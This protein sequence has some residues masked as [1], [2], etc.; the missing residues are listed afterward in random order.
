MANNKNKTL[1][2]DPITF[3]GGS[4][5]A[6]SDALNVCRIASNEFIV[7]TVDPEFW[8]ATEFYAKHNVTLRK[9][10]A[11]SW[12]MKKHNGAFYWL[13]QLYLLL[14]MLK[15]LVIERGIAKI[16][17]ASGPG[18]DMPMYL[19]KAFLNIEVTQF[20]HGN[21]GLSRSI[22][23]CLTI[24]DAVF[25][26]PSTRKSLKVALE[27]YLQHATKIEDTSA[28][29]ESYLK[30][31][32][33]QSFVN[34]IPAQRWPTECQKSVPICFWAASLLKWKG[35]D[36]LIEA[37]K[38]AARCKPI[39]LNVCFIR[40]VD[41]CLPVSKAP[42]LLKHTEWYEDPDNL[43]EI[44]SQSNIFVST[45][46]NEP[47]GLSIL[48][49][50]AAGMCVVIPQD[51][52]FWD[53][54]LTHNENCIK[55]QPNNADSLCDALLYATNDSQ[56][57]ERCCT[58]ARIVAEQYKAEYRYQRFAQHINGDIVTSMIRACE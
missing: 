55:Y 9:V 17:G 14:I 34:G 20:I 57:F 40:P 51:G 49:A 58:N 54:Q 13:N 8:K 52:S 33:Y 15:T 16:V 1:I 11:V 31:S 37:S 53:Q 56:A 36:T 18:I 4:K 43:D 12:L 7:L 22:G 48:E 5:I 23:Y 44:R 27:A 2:F 46:C 41:T 19:L 45:S 24:A 25:Y 26:L 39:A 21:V 28:L 32:S 42:V 30:S 6:T 10:S 47:F 3:K 29:A 50:L 38:L 35:L